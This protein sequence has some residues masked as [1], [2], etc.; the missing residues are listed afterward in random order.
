[1]LVNFLKDNQKWFSFSL[2]IVSQ[3]EK[4][5]NADYPFDNK[6]QWFGEK[7]HNEK[8]PEGDTWDDYWYDQYQGH[9]GKGPR[10]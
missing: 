4:P 2:E 8:P 9:G 1:M 5:Y 3:K 6:L 7:G 10:Q